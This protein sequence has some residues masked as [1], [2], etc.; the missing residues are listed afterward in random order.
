MLFCICI[1]TYYKEKNMKKFLLALTIVAMLICVF[2]ISVSAENRTS[3]SYTDKD[4][5][6]HNVPVVK[7]D[8]ATAESVATKL[9]NNSTMQALFVDNGAYSIVK[10]TDGTLTAYPTWYFIE[11]SGGATTYVAIS[12]IEYEYVNSKSG[13]TYNKGA[14]VYVEFPEGMTAVRNNSVFGKKHNGSPYETNVTDFYI[15][16]TVNSIESESFNSMPNLKNVFIEAG[17]QITSIPSGT[18]SYSTVQYIQFENLTEL[19]T[20]D[21]C[22]ST[23]LT[24]DIDLS[25]TKLKTIKAGA[26]EESRNIG[27]ITLPNSVET[28]ET[29]AFQNT[30]NAYL[31]SPYLPTS[32]T[33]IGDRFFAYNNNLLDTY[34]F[35]AGVKALGSEP[36]QDSKVSGDPAVKKLNLVFLG[37]VTG[38]VY[39]NGNGHQKHAEDVTVYFANNTLDQYNKNGFKVKPSSAS[40]T[41][42]ERAIKVVFCK[43]NNVADLIYLTN[44]DGTS[45]Q[46]GTF[47]MEGHTHLGSATIVP[48]DCGNDGSETVAC[49]ICDSN[50]V[51]VLE[52]TENHNFIDGVCDVCGKSLCPSGADH[53]LV[54]VALYDNGFLTTGRITEK[55]QNEGCTFEKKVKDVEPIFTFQ[56]YSAKIGGDK[57]TVGYLI[58]NKALNEYEETNKAKLNFGIVASVAKTDDSTPIS[59]NNGSLVAEA[60]AVMAQV[61]GAYC[62]FDFILNGFT[63]DYYELALVMCAYVYDGKNVSY[64]CTNNGVIGQYQ[65]AY[66]VTFD[67]LAKEEE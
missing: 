38:V 12:E 8:D 15:P 48:N 4:G 7:Y 11:P 65:S 35:P 19:E 27:K 62:G 41:D 23:K 60:N 10:A 31:A 17:N 14:M 26:F 44:T 3:I 29:R 13:K 22:T 32:L 59:V 56:G 2:A 42:V 64:L 54:L 34:I 66:S 1:Y 57:I 9:N 49:V 16:S 51:T 50:I 55:C 33:F 53:L 21:G 52:A 61:N 37:E 20:L 6:T 63:S 40:H 47:T 39:L 24:G 28:I 67:G 46:N 30:G 36:F 18:F 5:T 43:G 58:N 25:N 45:W